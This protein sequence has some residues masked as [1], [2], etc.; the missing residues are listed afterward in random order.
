MAFYQV[1]A[2]RMEQIL[3]ELHID[4]D[5]GHGHAKGVGRIDRSLEKDFYKAQKNNSSVKKGSLQTCSSH[6]FSY[7]AHKN[8]SSVKGGHCG[9]P[10]TLKSIVLQCTEKQL[11]CEEGV[12]LEGLLPNSCVVT[13]TDLQHSA[14]SCRWSV[15]PHSQV[16]RSSQHQSARMP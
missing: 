3:N 12:S 10:P 11:Q 6:H 16:C 4:L 7:D 1:F 5:V 15:A 8:N 9:G 2:L 14:G 13:P